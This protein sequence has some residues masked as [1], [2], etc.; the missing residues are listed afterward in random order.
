VQ[1]GPSLALQVVPCDGDKRKTAI[2][3]RGRGRML[4]AWQV[5]WLRVVST[6]RRLH[7][8]SAQISTARGMKRTPRP[9]AVERPAPQ[10]ATTRFELA[11][12]SRNDCISSGVIVEDGEGSA[13]AEMSNGLRR[14]TSRY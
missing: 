9:E 14:D 4:Q 2:L 3:M 5:L 8:K 11:R 1:D 6:I 12:H 10:R 13:V 7:G